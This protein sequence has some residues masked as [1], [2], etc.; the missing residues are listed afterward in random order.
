MWIECGEGN[1]LKMRDGA[2]AEVKEGGED[3][4]V[5]GVI[6]EK[7]TTSVGGPRAKKLKVGGDESDDLVIVE[8]RLTCR[9]PK[10]KRNYF[11][12]PILN[13][14]SKRGPLHQF[15]VCQAPV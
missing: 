5:D 14:C 8:D 1:N 4:G 9:I 6:G 7:P 2:D 13:T 12:C 15:L 11:W 10:Q 3:D